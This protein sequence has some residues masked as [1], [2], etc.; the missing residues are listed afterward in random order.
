[1]QINTQNAELRMQDEIESTLSTL[2]VLELD[3]A[4][5]PFSKLWPMTHFVTHIPHGFESSDVEKI[6]KKRIRWSEINK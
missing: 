6:K 5:R 4:I 1:M 3:D 2:Y